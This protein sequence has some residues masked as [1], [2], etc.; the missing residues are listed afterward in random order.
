MRPRLR[1][2]CVAGPTPID[3]P[4]APLTGRP[5]HFGGAAK[6]ARANY[7]IQN[8]ASD[9]AE[10]FLYDVIGWFAITADQFVKDLAKVTAPTIQLRINSPGGD[11]FD[12]IAIYNA[13]VRHPARVVT[14]VDG[15][16]ASAASIVA[17]AGDEVRIADGAFVMI[18]NAS[19]LAVGNED[20]LRQTA[21]LLHAIDG[22]LAGIYARRMDI[23]TDDARALMDAETWMSADD[24]I[25]NGFA[26]TI[27]RRAAVDASF[28]LS[29]FKHTPSGLRV[30]ARGSAPRKPDTLRDFE[31]LLREQGGFSRTE[32]A[33][34]AAS[35]WT[36]PKTP[37]DSRD[38]NRAPDLTPFADVAAALRSLSPR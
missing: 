35:G 6:A 20:D 29:G 33:R 7:R 25:D 37:A 5:S 1:S 30:A 11:V 17:L 38:E 19:A 13:L 18:H 22:A 8:A 26:D 32:A 2:A 24:A 4:R 16:A 14:T 27:D 23:S 12:G 9:E 31:S 21:D 15:L 34:I 28:D 36:I 10:I 3:D